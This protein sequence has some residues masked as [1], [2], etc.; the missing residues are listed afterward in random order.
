MTCMSAPAVQK[1]LHLHGEIFKMRSELNEE[2]V[3]E[4]RKD[5]LLGDFAEDGAQFARISFGLKN[6]CP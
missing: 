5:I 3:Y 2:L 6:L 4:I 1:V